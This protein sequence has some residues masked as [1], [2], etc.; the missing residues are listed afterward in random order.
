M[1]IVQKEFEKSKDRKCLERSRYREPKN[2]SMVNH[3][4]HA[5]CIRKAK[6][7]GA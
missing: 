4:S 2:P 1:G 7:A 6:E 3:L 5:H